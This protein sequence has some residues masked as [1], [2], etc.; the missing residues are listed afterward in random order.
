[1]LQAIRAQLV[2]DGVSVPIG[3]AQQVLKAV[4]SR[5]AADFRDLP[6]VLALGLTEQAAQIG[7]DPVAG[8]RASEIG[9]QPSRHIG[10]VGAPACDGAG[11]RIR[12]GRT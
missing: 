1:M 9:R 8:L 12:R 7:Q 5:R 2:A 10:H 3:P 6:A 4:G 11:C